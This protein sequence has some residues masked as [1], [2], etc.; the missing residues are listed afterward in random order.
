MENTITYL[1]WLELQNYKYRSIQ[2]LIS[3]KNQLENYLNKEALELST[4]HLKHF[5]SWVS[6]QGYSLVYQ[7]QLYWGVW[8][9]CR[10]LKQVEGIKIQAY[11]HK[12][13][14]V[15]NR[16]KALNE[17]QLKGIA[18]WLKKEPQNYWLNQALWALFYGCGL[19]RTE[20]LNLEKKDL[21]I[22]QKLLSVQ[23][24]KGGRKRL[25]P[26]SKKQLEALLNYINEERHS[27]KENYENKLF[28]GKRGGKAAHL[29]AN[30]LHHWQEGT[31][32]GAVLCWHVLR[33]SIATELVQKGMKLEEVSRFLGHSSI[34]STTRYLHYNPI[35]YEL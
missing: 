21:N 17:T 11:L 25:L 33:H 16:R 30:Q 8:V 7:R 32:L 9:Y 23:T 1:K 3:L 19:R 5:A 10:Y 15:D 6:N 24:I 18:T 34:E 28:I 20:A 13:K 35:S 22:S 4:E 12:I 2:T 14:Q 27:P 31:G 26:L 29:L